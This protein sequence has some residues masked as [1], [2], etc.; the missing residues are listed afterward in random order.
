MVLRKAAL[1][2][3]LL[4]VIANRRS[5]NAGA[6]AQNIARIRAILSKYPLL[7]A[8]FS[9]AERA[10]L[11]LLQRVRGTA[12]NTAVAVA[13]KLPANPL[14]CIP[15]TRLGA[16]VCSILRWLLDAA[17]QFMVKVDA[18]MK[19]LAP[20]ARF[21][22]VCNVMRRKQR[23]PPLRQRGSL[24]NVFVQVGLCLRASAASSGWTTLSLLC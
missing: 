20:F 24:C 2:L 14:R 4:R 13:S 7:A 6:I 16:A 23:A 3:L 18:A 17:L 22:I 10:A 11:L 5:L 15:N 1:A 8:L 9:A 19:G 21:R 12:H